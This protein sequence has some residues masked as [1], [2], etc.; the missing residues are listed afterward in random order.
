[1]KLLKCIIC[2]GEVEL[3]DDSGEVLKKTKCQKCGFA[4]GQFEPKTPEVLIIRK[5]KD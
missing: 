3:I 5:K 2:G 1:M 4:T